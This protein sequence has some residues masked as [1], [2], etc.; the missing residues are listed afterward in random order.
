VDFT[1]FTVQS[2]VINPGKYPIDSIFSFNP[3]TTRDSRTRDSG[4]GGAGDDKR[5]R[6]D[7]VTER[8]LGMS[9]TVTRPV[10]TPPTAAE[11][12]L[13]YVREVRNR[14]E[15]QPRTYEEF[16]NVMK[17]FKSGVCVLAVHLER[18]A[19]RRRR[20][21]RRRG[22]SAE[23]TRE[24]TRETTRGLT[25]AARVFDRR[26]LTADNVV[27]RVRRVFK[28]HAD[29]L[30]GFR[31]FLPEVRRD[32]GEMKCARFGTTRDDDDGDRSIDTP[33][34]RTTSLERRVFVVVGTLTDERTNERMEAFPIP[35]LNDG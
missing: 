10:T 31:A 4:R 26:R 22:G 30:D 5:R 16:L 24:T 19:S 11:T 29:L 18:R 28:G 17:D 14:F 2:L 32:V 21:R 6:R 27:T 35:R 1:D 3:P 9:T 23:W 15:R 12:A 13:A 34:A 20:R 25:N 33:R 7:R 8:R